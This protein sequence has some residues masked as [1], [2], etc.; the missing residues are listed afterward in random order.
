MLHRRWGYKSISYRDASSEVAC[1]RLAPLIS[2]NKT[3]KNPVA[4][5]AETASFLLSGI[6]SAEIQK[7]GSSNIVTSESTLIAAADVMD[8]AEFRQWPGTDGFQILRL[9]VQEKRPTK[10]LM[11]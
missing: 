5:T 10:K 8:A 3:D 9:G 11:M 6:C 7:M 4:K 2:R 1:S